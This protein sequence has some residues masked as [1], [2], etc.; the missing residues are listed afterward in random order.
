L[1]T[2]AG[3]EFEYEQFDQLIASLPN[4][5]IHKN[6][7]RASV[8]LI[9]ALKGVKGPVFVLQPQIEPEEFRSIAF[10]N[11]GISPANQNHIPSLSGLRPDVLYIGE[12]GSADYEILPNGSRKRVQDGD[13][14]LPISVIDLKNIT[15][16]NA[17]YSAEVCLYAFFLANWLNTQDKEITDRFFVCDQ[18]FLWRHVEMPRFTRILSTV[19]GGDHSKRIAALLED[20]R[21]GLVSYLVYMGSVRK[22]FVED[23]P[24]VVSLG[25]KLGWDGVEYHVNPRCSSCDWL[26]NRNWLSPVQQKI[27]DA[28]PEHYCSQSAELSDHLSK[29]PTLSRGA[30]RVLHGEGHQKVADLVGIVP[31]SPS[32]KK[33]TLL[34]KDR[35]QIGS[36][37]DSLVNNNTSID[38]TEKVA[39]LAK[40]WSAEYD[41]V[42]NFDAGVGLLTG[43]AIR[44]VLSAPYGQSFASVDQ[45]SRSLEFLGESAFVIPKD[46][47]IAEWAALRTFIEQFAGWVDR[48]EETFKD[49]GWGR[50]QTQICFWEPR[51]YEELCN[52]FGRHLLR[53]LSLPERSQRALAWIFPAEKLM[54]R[55]DQICPSIVFIRDVVSASVRLPQRFAVTLLGT[56][57]HYHHPKL[58]PRKID[59]YYVEPLGNAIPR[60]R[61]FDIWKSPTGTVRLF[62]K[63]VSIAE[64]MERYG[65]VLKAHTFA[66]GTVIARLRM[67]LKDVLDGKAPSIPLSIPSGM[68]SVAQDSK[69]WNQW[70]EVS[71]AAAETEALLG[72]I[73][74]AEWLEAAYKAVVLEEVITDHG[75]LTYT[76]RVNEE[77]TE[78]KIEEGD[79]YEALGIVSWPGF[80]LQTPRSIG[81]FVDENERGYYAPIHR[82][83][84]AKLE[85]FDRANQ[86][87][88]I[89][90]R[91]RWE[92]Y[93][94]VFDTLFAGNAIPIGKEPIYILDALPFNDSQG[95]RK[96]I[97]AIGNP[98]CAKTAP[99]ALEAMGKS[100]AK[101]I[102]AGKDDDT[103]IA[104]ILW[105]ADELSAA[106]LRTSAEADQLANVAKKCNKF[107]LNNS[108]IDAVR[109]CAEAQLSIIWGPPG[110]GK[111]DTLVAMLHAIIREQ[112]QRNI[113]ITGPNYRTVEELSG[114]L[115]ENL[116]GDATAPCDF[117]WV[118][119]RTREDKKDPYPV[120]S[121]MSLSSFNLGGGTQD[122]G[123]MIDSVQND[124]RTSIVSTTAH[125]VDRL[126]E[127][128]GTQGKDIE[129]IFDLVV[130]DESS[131]IPVTLAFRPMAA[132]RQDGQLVIAGD[133]LQM[134]PIYALEPP[135]NA[136][137]LV[138]SIQTYLIERFDLPR[139]ELLVNYR[140]NQ[141]LVDYAKTLG[142]PLQLQAYN[143]DKKLHLIKPVKDSV[144]S[145][146]S[147]LPQTD[148]YELVLDPS[149]KV[150][151]IIHD[152]P[153]SSQANELEAA[154]V[155]GLVFCVRH[156]MAGQLSINGSAPET[157][158]DDNTFF[159]VGI[160]IVTPH[161][162]QKALVVR[163]LL[164][165]FPDT[166]EQKVYE[167]VDT[168]ERF[169]G[170]ERQT[171]IVSYGVGDTDIIEG[172]EA[173]LLQMERT[174]VAVSRAMAKC[175]VLMPK[176]LA[177][178]L[179]SDQKAA[180]TSVAL[181]SYIE[182]F[183]NNRAM[184]TISFQ[185]NDR[186]AEVRWH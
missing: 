35:K 81:L 165:I 140:S 66:I 48:A 24:R 152:D 162:A 168:V 95:T 175:I 46:N 69:L 82:I 21:D 36:R 110:T 40:Y 59:N 94:K 102:P 73:T 136:E 31:S 163:A 86:I 106:K 123:E 122:E 67:D 146:A 148:A 42:V 63:D 139:Q 44:G 127:L 79:A 126:V 158:F 88:T 47:L 153:V 132:L 176:S 22:F 113:L 121:H 128:L 71:A 32:L 75:N 19:Q 178:H 38:T 183:C 172:E 182:E 78:A 4:H 92:G 166:D 160:G 184:T 98:K 62:G 5:V 27:F 186:D 89:S 45:P 64:A 159:D 112:K 131:Q 28:H 185:G 141:D 43:I 76:F 83:V 155:A 20:L 72:L 77:S 124:D 169:Q 18:V 91:P 53:I 58:L 55:D 9:G 119:S 105:A 90:F 137:Y 115:A 130:L 54:E 114:R 133:H 181:K 108:Q 154:L 41:I 125:I 30:A 25:D 171:I 68:R 99:E 97:Q 116:A 7:G 103:T 120:G 117:Y 15:E 149:R 39:G 49:N 179:P 142:Y 17:S 23:V 34:K 50:V 167:S 170:G 26:G 8:D 65:N 3:R 57:D 177:Y 164:E 93:R 151:A 74:R 61:I 150:T 143:R 33:H 145:L 60:E 147:N 101:K 96:I 80:P 12:V 104:R 13:P 52:A 10:N 157:E 37:A 70:S 29:M 84:A 6:N 100:A 180:E 138:A 11:L 111:T 161:K 144:A 87:A 14:R 156:S 107:Q 173:F 109:T 174:N 118:Y 135:V 56:A 51:Q 2:A 129:E 16:A 134:P 85:K 1:I